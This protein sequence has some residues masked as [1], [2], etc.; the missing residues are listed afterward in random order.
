MRCR[1]SQIYRQAVSGHLVM[2]GCQIVVAS[3][4]L[5]R[6]FRHADYT[7]EICK[8]GR[9][10]TNTIINWA[11]NRVFSAICKQIVSRVVPS[12]SARWS[13]SRTRN[14]GQY[15]SLEVEHLDFL[16]WGEGSVGGCRLMYHWCFGALALAC[17]GKCKIFFAR[18]LYN[19][20]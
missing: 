8:F 18:R 14:A 1:S 20:Q 13:V 6:C 4:L 11:I 9:P 12:N 2:T 17:I 16:Q 3:F 15:G 5:L 19:T 7:A 10:P